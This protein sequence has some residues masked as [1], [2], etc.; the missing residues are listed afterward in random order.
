MPSRISVECLLSLRG[1]EE[2]N[3]RGSPGE[4]AGI[5]SVAESHRPRTTL[6]HGHRSVVV[7]VRAVRVVQMAV[8]EI[9]DVVAMRNGGMAAVGTVH[10]AGRMRAALVVGRALAGIGASIGDFVFLHL[11]VGPLVMQ[12]TVVEVI[13][14]SLVLDGRMTA[15]R[16]V[17]VRVILVH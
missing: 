16:P 12:M 1:D 3:A 17:L 15:I 11:S 5:S 7:A 6:F 2:Q 13:D 4:S 8:D 10:V 14:V 9:V